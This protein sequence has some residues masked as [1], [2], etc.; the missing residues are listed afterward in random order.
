MRGGQEHG[1]LSRVLDV[2][3]DLKV[4]QYFLWLKWT[5]IDLYNLQALSL[6]L[7]LHQFPF[8]IDLACLASRREYLKLDKWLSDKIREHNDGFVSACIT[9]LQ[10]CQLW[11]CNTYNQGCEF[12]LFACFFFL[13]NRRKKILPKC[14]KS[15]F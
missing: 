10:V 4:I 2:A 8:V 7:N 14:V 15:Y 1:L 13:I 11:I 9:F 5:I 3:Q 12:N 6:V